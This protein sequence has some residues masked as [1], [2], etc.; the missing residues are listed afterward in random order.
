MRQLA[1]SNVPSNVVVYPNY[2]VVSE[3]NRAVAATNKFNLLLHL[4]LVWIM[5]HFCFKVQEYIDQVLKYGVSFNVE[6]A[7]VELLESRRT[8]KHN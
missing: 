5:A 2:Q 7:N 3:E 1:L 4:K 8:L 6:A